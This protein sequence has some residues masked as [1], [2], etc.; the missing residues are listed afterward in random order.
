MRISDLGPLEGLGDEAI[1]CNYLEVGSD[2]SPD[3]GR[4]LLSATGIGRKLQHRMYLDAFKFK[5]PESKGPK[6]KVSA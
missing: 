6:R 3:P 1:C 2:S 4:S 5:D